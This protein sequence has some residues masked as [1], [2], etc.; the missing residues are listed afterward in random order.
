M[1]NLTEAVQNMDPEDPASIATSVPCMMLHVLADSELQHDM[2]A[3]FSIHLT[4]NAEQRLALELDIVKQ[5]L[6]QLA[7]DR[8]DPL[9]KLWSDN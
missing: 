9:G 4:R 8:G 7:S 3:Q 2:L 6:A 1:R 5:Q